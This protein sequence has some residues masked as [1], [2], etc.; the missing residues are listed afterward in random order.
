MVRLLEV[1]LAEGRRMNIRDVYITGN[2][3]LLIV[4]N[5]HRQGW[6]DQADL[7]QFVKGV[8]DSLQVE[9][10]FRVE[11]APAPRESLFAPGTNVEVFC[12]FLADPNTRED[13]LASDAQ[14]IHLAPDVLMGWCPGVVKDA[15]ETTVTASLIRRLVTIT[16]DYRLHIGSDEVRVGRQSKY[17][18]AR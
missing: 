16:E 9:G 1:L 17:L 18:R 11:W 3:I 5:D 15:S 14:V 12:T 10:R 6:L 4:Q 8:L 7:E 2:T 13:P